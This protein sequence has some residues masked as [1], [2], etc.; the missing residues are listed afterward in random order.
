MQTSLTWNGLKEL[1]DVLKR[2]LNES[3]GKV[4]KVIFNV[5]QDGKKEAQRLS[6]TD[7]WFM[8][9]NIYVFNE[10]LN[11]EIHSP[12]SYSGYVNW[13]TRY[14]MAQP[15]FS[16]MFDYVVKKLENDITDVAEGL[17]K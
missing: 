4:S 15:F 8:H 9:D 5:S 1:D 7:S 3:E 16:D 10:Y 2:A 14:N 6:P 17:F 12:A 11:A 13:G